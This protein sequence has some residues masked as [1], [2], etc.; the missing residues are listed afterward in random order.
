MF[1]GTELVT[2]Y[3]LRGTLAIYSVDPGHWK[4]VFDPDMAE[5]IEVQGKILSWRD[6]AANRV[7]LPNPDNNE[8]R[9]LGDVTIIAINDRSMDLP[10]PTFK[11]HGRLPV[12]GERQS[13][14][15]VSVASPI[16]AR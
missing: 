13:T 7:G 15:V 16:R 5:R 6:G 1:R 10:R 12:T 3:Q 2:G 11:V 9:D 14:A 4:A 8:C